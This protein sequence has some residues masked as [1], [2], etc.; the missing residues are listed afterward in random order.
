MRQRIFLLAG[1]G[2]AFLVLVGALTGAQP[3]RAAGTTI[4]VSTT[5]DVLDGNDGVCSLREAII[6]ANMDAA[7]GAAAGE[8]PAGNG[9]D[10]INFAADV[11]GSLTIS[12]FS[13]PLPTITD[14]VSIVGPGAPSLQ[15]Y[16]ARDGS[17]FTFSGSG[18]V[19]SLSGINITGIGSASNGVY[20]GLGTL[21]IDSVSIQSN[22]GTGGGI[23]IWFDAFVSVTNSL[24]SDNSAYGGG[25]IYN[26]GTLILK[27]S[28]V[29]SNTASFSG[30]G[31]SNGILGK[32]TIVNSAIYGNNATS[33]IGSAD[34][35]GIANGGVMT[36]TNTTVANN[37]ATGANANGRGGGL[38]NNGQ[39]NIINSTISGNSTNGT[40]GGLRVFS[41]TVTLQN[42][43]I[44]NSATGGDCY[45]SGGVISN[46]GYNLVEDNSCGF[47]GGSD[48]NLGPLQDNG[49][50]TLTHALL[51]GS[52]AIDAGDPNYCAGATDQ[53][54]YFRL[55]DG[56]NDGNARCD[57]GAYEYNSFIF[58]PT[59]WVYLPLV[60][61]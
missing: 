40:G 60:R 59:N 4:T 39:L 52:P 7:S 32:A 49:G 54:G 20:I 27:S 38:H 19:F 9:A 11:S 44:A 3:A 46:G 23:T 37:Q 51:L 33:G 31:I 34:G 30:G 17:V 1:L 2:V 47:T 57:I 53:R 43:I 22:R 15:V 48:P 61:R 36:L 41:G 58:M 6:A 26:L 8:C 18:K 35:G 50:P 28:T 25:G 45:L 16:L 56:N 55:V 29:S 5:Q 14:S 10:I 21:N 13:Q 24:I 42:T 12:P